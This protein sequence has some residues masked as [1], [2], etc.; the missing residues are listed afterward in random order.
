M[1]YLQHLKTLNEQVFIIL[2]YNILNINIFHSILGNP[3]SKGDNE[4]VD[5][6]NY[7][8]NESLDILKTEVKDS[9]KTLLRTRILRGC[10]INIP[11]TDADEVLTKVIY[12]LLTLLFNYLL[13]HVCLL[14]CFCR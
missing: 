2:M 11:F 4:D 10:P 14:V 6:V 8:K 7:D 5:E 1:N 9:M 13:L 3:T 12:Y